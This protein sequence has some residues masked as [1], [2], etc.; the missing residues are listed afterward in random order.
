MNTTQN[1]VCAAGEAAFTE[2][3]RDNGLT[4]TNDQPAKLL[5]KTKSYCTTKSISIAA[6]V[7]AYATVLS[8]EN[9]GIWAAMPPAF[10]L[11]TILFWSAS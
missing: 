11:M 7:S 10:G 9:Y 5:S 2:S 8:F 6:F 4:A 1:A 3:R